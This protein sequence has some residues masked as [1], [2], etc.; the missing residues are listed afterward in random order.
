MAHNL[1]TQMKGLIFK[2][3]KITGRENKTG[4][5]WLSPKFINKLKMLT[6]QYTDKF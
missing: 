3:Y 5:V 1:E 6:L 2:T 4:W